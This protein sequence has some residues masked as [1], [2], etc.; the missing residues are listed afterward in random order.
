MKKGLLFSLLDSVFLIVFNI[1]FFSIFG[2]EVV[3][4][5]WI[6]YG[7]IHFSYI[8][9]LLTPLFVKR[10][11]EANLFGLSIVTVSL[12]YFIVELVLD[13]V[14]I[15]IGV[16]SLLPVLLSNVIITGIYI[17]IIVSSI[18]ATDSINKNTNQR[19]KENAHIKAISN[20]LLFLINKAN[21]KELSKKI[22]K[23]YD[24]INS[25]PVKSNPKI[26]EFEDEIK[27]KTEYL[28]AALISNNIVESNTLIERIIELANQRNEIMKR[29]K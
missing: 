26:F 1:V 2:K 14:L 25:S 13:S 17:A 19:D 6:A 27:I 11:T 15:F 24:I 4:P 12:I 7:F 20:R 22:E 10:K 5:I 16:F 21:D 18:L 8:M 29:Y 23:A 28:E 9:V 3:L